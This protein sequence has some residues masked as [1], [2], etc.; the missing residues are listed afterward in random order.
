MSKKVNITIDNF[1]AEDDHTR[2]WTAAIEEGTEDGWERS[3]AA[4]GMTPQEA[5]ANVLAE[6]GKEYGL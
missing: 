5:L 1:D 6:F 4:F 3:D 2:P